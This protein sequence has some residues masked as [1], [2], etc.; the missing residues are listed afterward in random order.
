MHVIESCLNRYSEYY[1]LANDLRKC[2]QLVATTES[3]PVSNG[4]GYYK[5]ERADEKRIKR[6]NLEAILVFSR[7]NLER[8]RDK[9]SREITVGRLFSRAVNFVDFVISLIFAKITSTKIKL[10]WYKMTESIN[11]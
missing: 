4:G 2:W 9:K 10:L 3:S 5:E 11:S 8:E 6:H 7:I 1:Q